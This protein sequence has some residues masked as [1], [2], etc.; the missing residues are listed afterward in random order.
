MKLKGTDEDVRFAEQLRA[1][2]VFIFEHRG[3]MET[4]DAINRIEDASWFVAHKGKPLSE[5]NWPVP[6]QLVID[7]ESMKRL[8][9]GNPPFGDPRY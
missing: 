7:E 2:L 9:E 5:Y 4:V 1:K 8:R 3:Q 6:E